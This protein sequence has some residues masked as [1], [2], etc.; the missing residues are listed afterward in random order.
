MWPHAARRGGTRSPGAA[1]A[2]RPAP[3]AGS[4]ADNA[5]RR[6]ES[7]RPAKKAVPSLGSEQE[8]L[9]RSATTA[10]EP[11]PLTAPSRRAARLCH[12]ALRG[13]EEPLGGRGALG[14]ASAEGSCPRGAGSSHGGAPGRRGEPS[15]RCPRRARLNPPGGGRAGRRRLAVPVPAP[16]SDVL[17]A[18]EGRGYETRPDG[19]LGGG[20]RG[21]R[22]SAGRH[23][24]GRDG[25]GRTGRDGTG[26]PV[27][28]A[29]TPRALVPAHA[30]RAAPP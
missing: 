7:A 1:P 6:G 21:L 8:L 5:W 19:G 15:C 11:S 20:P 16:L 17:G 3:G 22:G 23:G 29:A 26:R 27:A 14:A 28:A 25:A 9:L 18:G 2:T 4:G 12:G 30:W 13:S 10:P 24:T